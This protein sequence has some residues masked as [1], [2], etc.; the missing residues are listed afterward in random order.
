MDSYD[1][2]HSVHDVEETERL[3]YKMLHALYFR[4]VGR[5]VQALRAVQV[6]YWFTPAGIDL[7][8]RTIT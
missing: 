5:V 7:H 8:A 4:I 2:L 3:Y 1:C 6:G